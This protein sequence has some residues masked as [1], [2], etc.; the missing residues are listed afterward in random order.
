MNKR[1][2]TNFITLSQKIEDICDEEVSNDIDIEK[3]EINANIL[4]DHVSTYDEFKKFVTV[5]KLTWYKVKLFNYF[6]KKD[7]D[8][9]LIN[10]VEFLTDIKK[11]SMIIE[12][13]FNGRY[14]ERMM[15]NHN[16]QI[17]FYW[18]YDSW[19]DTYNSTN[20]DV[21]FRI[22]KLKHPN[23][24]EKIMSKDNSLIYKIESL[25][26]AQ[27]S[28][29]INEGETEIQANIILDYLSTLDEFN[30]FIK[31]NESR[32][33]DISLFNYFTCKND[34]LRNAAEYL[35]DVKTKPSNLNLSIK[36][37][38]NG[39]YFKHKM[40]EYNLSMKF[41]WGYDRLTKKREKISLKISKLNSF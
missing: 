17:N 13:S 37:S 20:G 29:E 5:E 18:H 3:T 32:Y 35:L 41:Y 27:K 6:N 21:I 14:F 4:L 36:F 22:L 16:F 26:N 33:L 31:N 1:P 12:F 30:K 19:E 8:N 11:Q 7:K 9:K 40:L 38:V 15:S 2:R 28:P 10:A 24:K 25:F 23:N 39:K 34:K